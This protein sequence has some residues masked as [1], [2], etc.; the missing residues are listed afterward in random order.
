MNREKIKICYLLESADLGGGVRVVFD[1]ARTLSAIGHE[2]VIRACFGDHSWYPY[3]VN[4][5][6]VEKTDAWFIV[7]E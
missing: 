4:I 7:K 1:Q 2:V 3:P 6:Y 5:R